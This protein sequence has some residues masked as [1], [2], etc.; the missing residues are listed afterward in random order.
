MSAGGFANTLRRGL[1]IFLAMLTLAA[2]V[3]WADSY[4]ERIV[5]FEEP[6]IRSPCGQVRPPT[7]PGQF[8]VAG[9]D[10]YRSLGQRIGI[11]V[12]SH[13]GF[14]TLT[15]DHY[16]ATDHRADLRREFPLGFRYA[17]S[18][19][20]AAPQ[21]LDDNHSPALVPLF[22]RRLEVPCW[23]MVLLL[24]LYPALHFLQGPL[25]RRRRHR[26]GQC[27]ACGYDLTHS[28]ERCP[29]CGGSREF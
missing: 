13:R 20:F 9:L 7:Y 15:F 5:T 25:Q 14:L 8:P 18:G 23:A 26:R 4:R 1:A 2:G 24:A 21:L 6:L 27:L 16:I 17:Q 11:G 3:L 22:Q 19:S 29:E 28:N 10:W 12:G